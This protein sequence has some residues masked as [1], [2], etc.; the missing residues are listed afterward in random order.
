MAIKNLLPTKIKTTDTVLAAFRKTLDEL[1]GVVDTHVALADQKDS[2]AMR[3]AIEASEARAE[4]NKASRSLA[5]FQ[6][7]LGEEAPA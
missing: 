3:A 5:R 1:K 4:A 2:E 6:E 7:I